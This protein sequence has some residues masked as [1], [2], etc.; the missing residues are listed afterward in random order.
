[1]ESLKPENRPYFEAMVRQGIFPEKILDTRPLRKEILRTLGSV[2]LTLVGVSNVLYI[3]HEEA[4]RPLPLPFVHYS[5]PAI[6][7]FVPGAARPQFH[8]GR[9]VFPTLGTL[10][11]S[12][13]K[14]LEHPH[15]IFST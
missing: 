7:E 11:R 4:Q 2:C 15:L 13:Q 5:Q 9:R 1:M 3:H 10:S 8:A 6:Y 12:I 14:Y